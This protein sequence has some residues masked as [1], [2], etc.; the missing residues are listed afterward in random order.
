[1]DKDVDSIHK[2][3][4]IRVTDILKPLIRFEDIPEDKLENAR[5]RGEAIHEWIKEYIE[6]RDTIFERTLEHLEEEYHRWGE[7]FIA[8]WE[9]KI[10]D[11][12]FKVICTERRFFDDDLMLTG[13]ID[14][15]YQQ[16]GRNMI[17]DFKFTSTKSKSW[18]LQLSAYAYL[19]RLEG[20]DIEGIE[21]VHFKNGEKFKELAYVEDFDLF[22]DCLHV[23]HYFFHKKK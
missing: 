9:S 21:I 19:V 14:I 13:K 22:L 4:Y 3:E 23:Y 20:F 8:W 16:K 1:M 7:Q 15:I 18:P 2:I 12:S 5:I 11:P 17:A 6:S 10:Q